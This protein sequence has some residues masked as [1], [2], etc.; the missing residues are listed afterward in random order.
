[1]LHFS[2][3]LT[4]HVHSKN[5]QTFGWRS[6]ENI[7]RVSF[8]WNIKIEIILILSPGLFDTCFV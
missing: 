2:F 5:R 6:E 8:F 1:M 3:F 4:P 7:K